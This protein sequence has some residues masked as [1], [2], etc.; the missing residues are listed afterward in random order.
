M[1]NRAAEHRTTCA[2]AHAHAHT[3]VCMPQHRHART[4]PHTQTHTYAHSTLAHAHARSRS[5]AHK[6]RYL[7]VHCLQEAAAVLSRD[8]EAVF[9]RIQVE[10]RELLHEVDERLDIGKPNRW[11]AILALC[12]RIVY[13]L[14]Q[15]RLRCEDST[16]PLRSSRYL[17]IGCPPKWVASL[18]HLSYWRVCGFCQTAESHYQTRGHVCL[19]L[20]G[21]K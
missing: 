18:L 15:L 5:H 8:V 4:H 16:W 3:H 20:S 19:R 14:A 7:P 9:G 12:T 11:L 17:L 2:P 21:A 6:S 1:P 10:G 13:L